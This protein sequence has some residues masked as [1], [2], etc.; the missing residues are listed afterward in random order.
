MYVASKLPS[1]LSRDNIN[2]VIG[3]SVL[4]FGPFDRHVESIGSAKVTVATYKNWSENI[5][6][7]YAK[8][9]LSLFKYQAN[10]WGT[11]LVYKYLFFFHPGAKNGSR[12]MQG[13]GPL[14]QNQSFSFASSLF[15]PESY[16]TRFWALAFELFET[17]WL[18]YVWGVVDGNSCLWFKRGP[19]QTYAFK[20][21]AKLGLID[22]ATAAQEISKD[23]YKY[24]N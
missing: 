13:A 24:L 22:S 14:S 9:A 19:S 23:Y 2:I 15:L 18:N 21:L 10:V 4:G 8:K 16:D 1:G 3:T 20:T 6:A 17:R 11:S 7:D 12:I 5:K